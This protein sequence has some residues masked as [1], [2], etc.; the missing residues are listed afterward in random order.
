MGISILIHHITTKK[1][2][3]GRGSAAYIF[4]SRQ[5]LNSPPFILHVVSFSMASALILHEPKCK[6]RMQ[7]AVGS[8]KTTVYVCLSL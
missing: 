2:R 1:V 4:A 7:P 6:L 3:E 8:I 5:H